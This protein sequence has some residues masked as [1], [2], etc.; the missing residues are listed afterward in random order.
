MIIKTGQVKKE[1]LKDPL[2]TLKILEVTQ[3]Y[4]KLIDELKLSNESEVL[5]LIDELKNNIKNI[6]KV[7]NIYSSNI[8]SEIM[9]NNI[10]PDDLKTYKSF[11]TTLEN[12]FKD[13]L[14]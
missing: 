8:F 13:L 6:N 5:E 10:S 4:S 9:G 3:F 1:F 7:Y 14:K 2:T 11:S 12:L